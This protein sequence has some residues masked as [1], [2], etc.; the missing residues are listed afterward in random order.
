MH[1]SH[2]I[3]K[4]TFPNG[5]SYIGQTKQ[6]FNSYMN[7]YLNLSKNENYKSYNRLIYKAIR[8]YGWD[9][10]LKEILFTVSE[11]FVDD[12]ERYFIKLYNSTNKIFGYNI[13]D[14]G[15]KNKHLSE[16][17]RKK[18]SIANIGKIRSEEVKKSLSKQRSGE[19]NVMWGKCHSKETKKKLSECGIG[20][21]HTEETK[22]KLSMCMMGKNNPMF[23]K[24]RPDLVEINRNNRGKENPRKGIPQ[25]VEIVRKKFKSINMYNSSENFIKTFESVK[26]AANELNVT[27]GFIC[28]LLKNKRKTASGYTFKYN[29]GTQNAI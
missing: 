24:K 16:E 13:E 27:T 28:K 1:Y 14:G 9:N 25:S 23:G 21:K 11:E 22:K 15:C 10:V 26:Q 3:Y 19:N 18:I 7:D 4:L 20:R 8:K 12:V 17:T 6:E 2:I 5:K 29:I